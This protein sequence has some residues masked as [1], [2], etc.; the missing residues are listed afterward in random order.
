MD[1]NIFLY[2]LWLGGFLSDFPAFLSAGIGLV[3]LFVS[4]LGMWKLFQKAGRRPFYALIPF[5]NYYQLFDIAWD[6]RFGLLFNALD[7]GCM[8]LGFGQGELLTRGFRG[9]LTLFL[10]VAAFVLLC[11]AKIKL[12]YSFGKGPAFCYGLIFMEAAFITIL[13]FDKSEY[14]GR[15]LRKYN[16]DYVNFKNK[17]VINSSAHKGRN[18]MITLHKYR[19]IIALVSGTLVFILTFRAVAISLYTAHI[20][21]KID[22][23]YGVFHYFTVNSN[24]L[25]A[26]GAAFMIPYAIEG[27]R[28]KRFVFPRWV[29]LFQY[30]GAICTTLTMFFALTFI[31]STQGPEVAVGG[32]NFWLHVICPIMS[33]ALLFTVETDRK[34]TLID[35][36]YC[37]LPFYLY[38]LVYITNVVLVGEYNG[39]WKDIYMFNTYLPA[40]ISAPLMYMFG[41]FVATTIRV[42]Y[43]RLSEKH[44]KDFVA[45]WADDTDPIG[46]NIE[47]YGLGRY[48]GRHSD[49]NSITVP[50]DI[51]EMLAEKYGISVDKL[52]TIYNKGVIDGLKEHRTYAVTINQMFAYIFGLP[53]KRGSIIEE[54]E[55]V[56]EES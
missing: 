29:T 49:I 32:M 42:H 3:Y 44:K 26:V 47:I 36:L 39:G 8:I 11:I 20:E 15:T 38:S 1:L 27:I 7:L 24:I 18:F 50:I 14:L 30:S 25:S 55:T 40:T 35:S 45:A 9:Y 34:L 19:S 17:T 16:P 28:K 53:E 54:E 31:L 52:C 37:L 46:I 48:Q 13:G 12:S 23:S 43:N 10:F 2:T 41:F 33:L 51:F 21:Q 4:I 56:I 6:K 22:P 5:F